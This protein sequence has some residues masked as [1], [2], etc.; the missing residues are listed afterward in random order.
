MP[1]SNAD[2]LTRSGL[3]TMPAKEIAAM[4]TSGKPAVVALVALTD[5]TTGTASNTIAATAGV[6]TIA[7]PQSLASLTAAAA[8]LMTNY[9]PGFAFE[10]L[11]LEWITT[12]IGVGALASLTFNLEIGT[13]NVTGGVLTLALGDTAALG[14]KTTATAITALN[15]G[16]AASTL[17]IEVAA[18]GTIFTTGAGYFLLKLRNMDTVNAAASNAAKINAIIAALKA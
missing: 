12:T 14:Q 6:V 17:S 4:L 11:G 18:G 9:V 15:T 7:I 16:T 5:S 13:T 3:P 1:F 2:I 8:D 10:L